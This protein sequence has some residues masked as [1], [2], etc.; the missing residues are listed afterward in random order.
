MWHT[1]TRQPPKIAT[2]KA[3][4]SLTCVNGNIQHV[5]CLSLE[6]VRRA[7]EDEIFCWTQQCQYI[8]MRPGCSAEERDVWRVSCR[9]YQKRVSCSRS[10]VVVVILNGDRNGRIKFFF[11]PKFYFILF[12]HHHLRND[13]VSMK[14]WHCHR[15]HTITQPTAESSSSLQCLSLFFFFPCVSYHLNVEN[16]RIKILP[17]RL[18][19][20]K[21][22]FR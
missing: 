5:C 9:V 19:K 2:L 22:F 12:Y 14:F 6:T 11:L 18:H 20:K 10:V 3:S 1:H 4:K 21:F 7:R 15:R 13:T 16:H 17:I 8:V